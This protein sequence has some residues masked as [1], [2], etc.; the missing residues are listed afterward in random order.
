MTSDSRSGP[1]THAETQPAAS[2]SGGQSESGEE[3]PWPPS[4]SV[5]RTD[6]PLPLVARGKV[7]D[8]YAVDD[9]RLLIVATDRISAFDVVLPQP[10]PWK[11]AVLTQLTAWWLAQVKE[12]TSHHL[13]TAEPGRIIRSVPVLESTYD[14][15]AMRAM[16]VYRTRVVPIECVVRGYLA[17]SAWKEYR[18]SG[19]LAGEPLPE[20]LTERARLDPPIFSPATKAQTGHDENITFTEM[21]ERVGKETAT[22]LRDRSIAIY[23]RARAIAHRRGLT[24]ADTKLEFG[25]LPDRRIILIDEVLTPDSSR[26]WPPENANLDNAPP[27]LENEESLDKQP[28]R[29]YLDRLVAE[30]RWNREPPAPDLPDDVVRATSERYRALFQRL[31]HFRVEAFPMALI[32]P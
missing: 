13:I 3:F 32:N 18:T 30:G 25:V 4:E 22:E 14:D 1:R 28:V 6:L 26:Y 29:D 20:G 8:I 7:R 21:C 10:I 5:A 12:I 23:E 11:G 17:G 19:T 24:L 16:L 2:E 31:T 15:W 9:E 27:W